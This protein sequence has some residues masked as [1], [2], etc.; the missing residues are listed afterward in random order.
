M[1]R[2]DVTLRDRTCCHDGVVPVRVVVQFVWPTVS[3]ALVVADRGDG[4]DVGCDGLVGERIGVVDGQRRRRPEPAP[5]AAAVGA[6]PGRDDEH[7]GAELVDLVS[8]L[9]GR[10]VADADAED[11]RGD[12]DENAEHSQRRPESMR[13]DGF[14][15]GS[16]RVSPRHDGCPAYPSTDSCPSR[17]STTRS[18]SSR[19]V[20]FVGDQHDRASGGVQLGEQFQNVAAG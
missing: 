8:Y 9:R 18:A 6:A 11:D 5:D 19:D 16:E 1:N 2:P 10:T 13:A 7:V 17:I 14:A 12:A 3:S 20:V 4:F 15:R